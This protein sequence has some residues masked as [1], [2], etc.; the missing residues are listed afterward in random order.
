MEAATA[1]P[2]GVAKKNKRVTLGTAPVAIAAV[3][4]VVG[5]IGCFLK[6]F[7]VPAEWAQGGF[8]GSTTYINTTGG[9]KITLATL[10]IGLVFVLIARGVHRK[11]VLWGAYVCGAIAIVISVLAAAGGFSVSGT[12]VKASAS[13]AVFVALVGSVVLFVGAIAARQSAKPAA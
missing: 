3:G 13:I 12:S 9:A 1:A 7:N 10:V 2:I 4:T 6:A 5:V 8:T 11:G